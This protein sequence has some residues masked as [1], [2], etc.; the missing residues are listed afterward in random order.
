MITLL[1]VARPETCGGKA[2]ALGALARAGLPV[3][4]GFVVPFADYGVVPTE[5]E[6]HLAELGDP[7]VAVRSSA[8]GEDTAAASAAGQYES[9][10]G[11]RGAEAVGE[12][13]RTCWQSAHASRVD[14]YRR[15]VGSEQSEP[16]MAVLVQR[17][18]A[19]DVSGVMF[20]PARPDGPTRIE[21]AWGLGPAIVGG[22]ITPDSYEV[23]SDGRV[24]RRVIA[25]K[26]MRLDHDRTGTG[27]ITRTVPETHQDVPTL[28]DSTAARLAALGAEATSLLGPAQDIEW[29]IEDGTIWL[30]QARPITVAL[31]PFPSSD[32]TATGING[33]PGAKG[34]ATGI[35]RV[36]RSPS[37]FGRVHD[38]DI[39]I[40]PYTDPAWT[41]LFSVAAAV[42]TETGGV[43][44]HAAIVAR[45]YGIPCVLGVH[46]ATTAVVDGALVTV[47]G[48]AGTVTAA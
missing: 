7:P 33:T 43:L 9:V 20:T 2:A 17:L 23:A 45:E 41:P 21:S 30:L 34:T 19:A 4:A 48:T 36:I 14:H 46:G 11:V 38:G 42:V 44:A 47:D 6:Q 18:V 24:A 29:A 12:A 22:T 32:P 39:L 27:L 1:E 13:V 40:C 3:P 5:L 26:A 37:E 8:A 16:G 35:A 15:R 31:P 10:I 28:N 25:H